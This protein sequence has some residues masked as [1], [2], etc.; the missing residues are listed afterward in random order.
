[1]LRDG[2]DRRARLD[3]VDKKA[4]LSPRPKLSSQGS[5]RTSFRQRQIKEPELAAE[6]DTVRA[7]AHGVDSDKGKST[8][9]ATP[10]IEVKI[11]GIA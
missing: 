3:Q 11:R 5:R 6:K 9:R 10:P 7:A 4:G 1:V 2:Q 8:S